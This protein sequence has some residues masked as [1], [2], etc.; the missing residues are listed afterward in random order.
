MKNADIEEVMD[1][2][3][4]E[5][6]N[7]FRV[8]RKS[9]LVEFAHQK[10]RDI[11]QQNGFKKIHS[12]KAKKFF[13][14]NVFMSELNGQWI[15]YTIQKYEA[16]KFLISIIQVE[17]FKTRG[18]NVFLFTQPPKDNLGHVFVCLT[19]H[20][21]DRYKERNSINGTRIYTM[22]KFFKEFMAAHLVDK[23]IK[24]TGTE[25]SIPACIYVKS[26]IMLG[27][28]YDSY[29]M[30]KTFVSKESLKKVQTRSLEMSLE[31]IITKV[32]NDE[33]VNQSEEKYLKNFINEEINRLKNQNQTT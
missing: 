31:K 17:E 20:F 26:G 16:D 3:I 32:K 7:K 22:R 2:E 8:M 12:E 5:L 13:E 29:I 24:S 9:D 18:G 19:A 30:Y 28:V 15:A 10:L 14:D 27:F 23:N 11:C 33:K 4:L 21:F 25:K 6:I 1:P